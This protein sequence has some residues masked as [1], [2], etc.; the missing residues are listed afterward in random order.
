MPSYY[1][2]DDNY[3]DAIKNTILVLTEKHN[4][5]IREIDKIKKGCIILTQ[6]EAISN[7]TLLKV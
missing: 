4:I 6:A 2:R 5:S 3:P 1:I 7:S